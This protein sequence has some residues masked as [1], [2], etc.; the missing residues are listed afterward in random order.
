MTNQDKIRFKRASKVSR[1]WNPD[2]SNKV[3]VWEQGVMVIGID[4]THIYLGTLREPLGSQPRDQIVDDW[5]DHHV[6]WV[7]D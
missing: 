1:H 3:L 5:L 4:D 2:E 6:E 7:R